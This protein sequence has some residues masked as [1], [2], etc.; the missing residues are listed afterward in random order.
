MKKLIS[1]TINNKD[2]EVAVNPNMTLADFLRY[3]LGLTGTKKG[4]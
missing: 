2:Y 1:L 3:E 4:C